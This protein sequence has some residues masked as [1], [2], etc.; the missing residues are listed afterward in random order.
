MG[1]GRWTAT[2]VA[3][4]EEG[5]PG[6]KGIL[7]GYCARVN[8]LHVTATYLQQPISTGRGKGVGRT[9][10][11]L[12]LLNLCA[13][14]FAL[15]ALRRGINDDRGRWRILLEAFS[16]ESPRRRLRCDG[17]FDVDLEWRSIVCPAP[18]TK[19]PTTGQHCFPRKGRGREKD[20]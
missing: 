7:A 11:T 17:R 10:T 13:S 19:Q 12:L 6:R 2:A 9:G 8:Q 1:E 5:S 3:A 4:R 14:F 18:V 16:H 15:E 20:S